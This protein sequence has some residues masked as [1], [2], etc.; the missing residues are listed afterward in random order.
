MSNVNVVG[1]G[2]VVISRLG[3]GGYSIYTYTVV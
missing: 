3:F 2:E 1:E